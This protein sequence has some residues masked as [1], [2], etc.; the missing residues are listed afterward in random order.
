M[1]GRIVGETVDKQG[2]R[3]YVLTLSTREQ[4]IKREKATSNICTNQAWCALRAAMYLSTMGKTGLEEIG[5]INHLNTAYFAESMKKFEHVQ[6]KFDHDFYNEVV[7]EIKQTDARNFIERLQEKKVIPGIPLQW[8]FPEFK[9]AI[10]INFTEM[11]TKKDID[12]L[13]AAIGEMR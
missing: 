11:H 10:L 1:P 12:F 13:V 9:N 8:F 7:L 4:H 5:K 3:G 2:R 6:I